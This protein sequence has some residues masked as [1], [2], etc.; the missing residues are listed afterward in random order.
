VVEGDIYSMDFVDQGERLMVGDDKGRVVFFDTETLRPSG[1]GFEIASDC[2]A[3]G[4][5]DSG[6]AMLFDDSQDVPWNLA[7]RVLDTSSGKN[8]QRGRLDF[9]ANSADF[10]PNGE[11]VAVTGNTGECDD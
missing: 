10:S 4:D 11:H 1:P 8:P 7:W 3:A 5:P 9:R 2:C 6:S